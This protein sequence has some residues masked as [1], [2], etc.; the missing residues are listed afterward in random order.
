[1]KDYLT[2]EQ[3][4]ALLGI[5]RRTLYRWAERGRVPPAWAWTRDGLTPYVGLPH[6]K[7]GPMPGVPYGP[8]PR[9]E[10]ER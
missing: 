4:A 6:M 8:R 5:T 1:M 2:G 9:K 7:K 3:A 10:Q